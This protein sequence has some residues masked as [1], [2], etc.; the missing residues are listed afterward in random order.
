MMIKNILL[1][2]KIDSYYLFSKRIIGIEITKGFIFATVSYFQGKKIVIEQC[3][4]ITIEQD[5]KDVTA[6]TVQALKK[7]FEAAGHVSS[8]YTTISCS[9]VIFKTMKLPFED[10]EKIER[11]INFEVEPL[12]PFA[13]HDAIV[14]FVITKT[15]PEE[16]SAEILVAAVQKEYIKQI[17]DIFAQ[18]NLKLDAICVDIIGLYGLYNMI[19]AYKDLTDGTVLMDIGSHMTKIAYILDGKLLFIRTLSF[20]VTHIAKLLAHHNAT[21][22][23]DAM[24]ALLQ[25]G[26]LQQ[27][28]TDQT[29]S[30]N[31]ADP[32]ISK[33]KFTLQSFT[34]QSSQQQIQR[35]LLLG[36]GAS[37]KGM[38]QWM[39]QMLQTPCSLFKAE[40]ITKDPHVTLKNMSAIPVEN[41]IS[42]AITIPNVIT[43]HS[44]M[45][46]KEFEAADNRLLLKQLLVAG[47]LVVT[48][49]VSL[50]VF[51]FFQTSK[52][53]KNVERSKKE[54]VAT[55]VEWFPEIEEGHLDDM[56]E[57]AK[58]EATKE[59]RLWFSFDRSTK[60]SLLS[61]LLALTQLDR[62]GLGLIVDKISIDQDKGIML[63]K[64][65]VKDHDAL[66]PLQNE[67][68]QSKLFTYV[69]PQENPNF[70]MELR[71]ATAS[72]NT[73]AEQ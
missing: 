36:I 10:Y 37:I 38:D 47:T 52:L 40:Q 56:I 15:Y 18:A 29:K 71:F 72:D 24:E 11:V 21:S 39:Q 20:G 2:E 59:E 7:L 49:F 65:Q 66:A 34:T 13:I 30:S 41:S 26:I 3:F 54:A 73:G 25:Y 46:A 69:Q 58:E 70:T 50:F 1:P 14:D 60:N 23:Q 9:Q 48:L 61:F 33:I 28:N 44:N 27:E 63:L 68:K 4:Q 62:E 6:R 16:K 35:I 19:P 51:N 53:Q 12:L 57:A 45:L 64:A 42:T 22:K 32:F 8:I 5:T 67:L 43:L 17:V 55:L 31:D